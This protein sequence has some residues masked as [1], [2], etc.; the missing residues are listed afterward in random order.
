VNSEADWRDALPIPPSG[1][2]LAAALFTTYQPPQADLLVEHLLP[3]LVPLSRDLGAE[4]EA[5]S[6]Y[7]GELALALERLRGKLTVI[8]SPGLAGAEEPQESATA[9]AYPWLWRY[10][11]LFSTGATGSAVQHA[12]LWMFHW[13]RPGAADHEGGEL[14]EIAV[15]STNLTSSALRHQLQAGWR[16]VVALESR[17]LRTHQASWG[18]LPRF[19]EALG[20]SAGAAASARVTHFSELLSRS[21]SPEGV[22][23]VASVPGL[24]Q[25]KGERG[26]WGASALG[27]VMRGGTGPLHL[28]V[29]VPFVGEWDSATFQAW[30]GDVGTSPQSTSLS[31]IDTRHPWARPDEQASTWSV[32]RAALD[33]L[34]AEG[35]QLRRLGHAGD[36]PVSVFH[37]R[38]GS[39]DGRWSHAKLYHLRRGR[40]RRLLV[41]SAN[42][43]VAAWGAGAE[44]PRNFEL[45]VL[46]HADWPIE[47]EASAFEEGREPY[48]AGVASAFTEGALSWGEATWDGVSVSLRCR[49]AQG[50]AAIKAAVTAG[51]AH[52]PRDIRLTRS[53][54]SG[55][56]EGELDWTARAGLPATACFRRDDL[57]LE[58]PVLD[59][60]PPEAFASTPLPEVDAELAQR[61]RDALLL[62]AYGGPLVEPEDL[63]RL[64][65]DDGLVGAPTAVI[66]E[67]YSVAAF[68]S[69]RGMF[70]VVERWNQQL[71][72]SAAQGLEAR[73]RV[74]RD[75]EQLA[76][77]F[78]RRAQAPGEVQSRLPARLVSEEFQW[79]LE[80]ARRGG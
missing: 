8:S 17:A 22:H 40:S 44:S 21:S 79:R 71:S 1:Y 33:A 24:V 18:P 72:A 20:E 12:K 49:A 52:H 70:Q 25:R 19:L 69:A 63:Q 54:A 59:L 46:L 16:A 29:C 64:S 66:A 26:R 14:L 57:V 31:W 2:E 58:V 9:G 50:S 51:P 4:P 39:E 41:T 65:E 30:C 77:L 67:D 7:F 68:G 61:L 15:S 23:F 34:E 37:P 45:G 73:Q 11:S 56:W 47:P 43:S 3:S 10:V 78:S 62:E 42:F 38:Q 55:M 32:S 53:Q 75:G 80:E 35:L 60:R 28:R 74:L 76:S 48:T 36:G 5:R 27:A 6:L 13:V